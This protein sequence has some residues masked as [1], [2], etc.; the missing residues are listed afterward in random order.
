MSCFIVSEIDAM[1]QVS[2]ISCCMVRLKT[3][4]RAE[5]CHS[6]FWDIAIDVEPSDPKCMLTRAIRE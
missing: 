4:S 2:V 1:T 6:P 5:Y 3:Q